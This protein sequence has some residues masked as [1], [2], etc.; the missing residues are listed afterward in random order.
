MELALLIL[1]IVIA[2][3]WLDSMAKRERAILL[4]KELAARFN[5]QLLDETVA[6][7]KLWLARNSR[8]RMHLLRTYEFDVSANG[9]DRLNCHLMLLGNQLGS[10]HIPP[11]QQ[12]VQ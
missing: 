2:W 6:C 11:Y 8:G 12:P 1:M 5:L 7:S 3:F 10:W 9:A 4:G